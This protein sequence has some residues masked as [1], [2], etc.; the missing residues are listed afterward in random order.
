MSDDKVKEQVAGSRLPGR[1]S[2][3]LVVYVTD[4]EPA[5]FDLRVDAEAGTFIVVYG[6]LLYIAAT[7]KALERHMVEL[8]REQRRLTWTRY[9]VIDYEAKR[10]TF[11]SGH[12]YSLGQN[13]PGD[14]P[15]ISSLSLTWEVLDYSTAVQQPGQT[16]SRT[17][18]RRVYHT[19][20]ATD[21]NDPEYCIES[22]HQETWNY[23]DKLPTGAVPYTAE[24]HA[25]L[26][27]IRAALGKLDGRL[28]ALF[29]GSPD[30]LAIQL[31][32]SSGARLLTAGDDE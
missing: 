17:K 30:E 9:I 8:M 26:V 19:D 13:R 28:N 25:L 4:N 24:R 15:E 12:T 18:T 1:K 16:K 21:P 7:R 14:D 29:T 27:D 20:V 6:G 3:T 32:T 31:D 5:R 23:D 10:G 2:G 11:G 22:S